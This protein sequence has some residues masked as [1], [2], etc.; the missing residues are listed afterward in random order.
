MLLVI[1]S[2]S[3]N[4]FRIGRDFSIINHT[5]SQ[6]VITAIPAKGSLAR[7]PTGN[8]GNPKIS[9]INQINKKAINDHRPILYSVLFSLQLN[10]ILLLLFILKA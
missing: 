4:S 7:Y 5:R 2:G 6:K 9:A 10:F 3:I 1:V 8:A